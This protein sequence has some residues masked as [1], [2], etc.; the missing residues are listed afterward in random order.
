MS[1][2]MKKYKE[3]LE[4]T[5]NPILLSQISKKIDLRGIMNYAKKKGIKVSQL[6]ESEKLKFITIK[7]A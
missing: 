3:S 6:S 4:D 1:G 5:P 2:Q 7:T